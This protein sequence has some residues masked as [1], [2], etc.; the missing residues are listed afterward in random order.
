MIW[1]YPAPPDDGAARHL[2][3]GTPLPDIKLEA[4]RGGPVSLAT[5]KGPAVVFVY[6]WTGR[7]GLPNPP[8]WDNIPGAHGSTP[9]AEG[10]RD[11]HAAFAGRG[12]Q[13]FGLS[14]QTTS[15]QRELTDRLALPFPVLSDAGFFV[16]DALRLPTF[17]TGGVRYLKR[18]TMIARDGV[19]ERV[20]YPVHPPDTH[21]DDVLAYITSS[22]AS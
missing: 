22:S 17:E 4:T 2:V 5:L 6:P 15:H 1:P 11:L 20:V 10:F 16:A 12:V 19:I 8:D 18:L 13:V 21:A 9:E 7:P 3:A 14:S